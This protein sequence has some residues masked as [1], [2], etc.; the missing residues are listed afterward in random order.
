MVCLVAAGCGS[1]SSTTTEDQAGEDSTCSLD[2]G[3]ATFVTGMDDCEKA[4][5][6]G[7][8]L[9]QDIIPGEA[10]AEGVDILLGTACGA[11]QGDTSMTSDQE[12]L[13]LAVELDAQGVCPGNVDL[14]VLDT[15]P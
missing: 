13:T 8:Q 1:D 10:S 4:I 15:G 2:V 5:E 6:L 9:A 7:R 12:S 11:I 3:G 14:L